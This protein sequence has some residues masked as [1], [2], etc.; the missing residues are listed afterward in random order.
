MPEKVGFVKLKYYERKTAC[1]Y[2]YKLGC[3]DDKF[4]KLFKTY[5]GEDTIYNFINNIIEKSKYCSE[6]MKKHLSKEFV[7]TKEDNNDFKNST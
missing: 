6:V 3:V 7:M 4:S 2:G 1:S 5:L